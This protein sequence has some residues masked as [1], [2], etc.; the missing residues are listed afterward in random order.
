MTLAIVAIGAGS[1]VRVGAAR[2]ETWHADALSAA[3]GG[4]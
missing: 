3:L 4:P 1:L 2:M